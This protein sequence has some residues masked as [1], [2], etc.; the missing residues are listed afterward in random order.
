L[1]SPLYSTSISLQEPYT[2]P[3]TDRLSVRLYR[4][5][6][7]RCL[8][9]AAL[10]K[11]LVL[12]L[13]G[14]ELIEEGVGFGVPVVKYADKTFFSS[15]AEVDLQRSGAGYTLTK[16]FTLDTVSM[17]KL[18]NSSYID[19]KIYSSLRKTFQLLYLK[20]GKLNPLFNKVMEIR[21]LFNIKTEFLTVK[22]RGTIAVTYNCQPNKIDIT[23]DYSDIS[24]NRCQEV[25]L[26]NEQGSSIFQAYTDNSGK[27]LVGNKIG[28]WDRVVADTAALHSN[29]GRL[30]FSLQGI[31]G[32]SLFRGYEHTHKR[33]SWAGLS[34]SL[35][36]GDGA[37][38]YSIALNCS[39]NRP[40][41]SLIA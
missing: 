4:D 35:K 7:P 17:K 11:G 5:C 30:G 10:Q 12:L 9:T 37:V 39:V 28:A 6:R 24:L 31:D 25:L 14:K 33:F 13:N 8:E 29:T 18:G 3:L 21:N 16:A 20:H 2:V 19:D 23:A 40:H 27:R 32:A 36:P 41:N 15:T 38:H 1:N 26:L 22:P 34:Y